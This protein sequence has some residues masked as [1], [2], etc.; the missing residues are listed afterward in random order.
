MT[1][2]EV[3]AGLESFGGATIVE[4][5]AGGPASDSYFVERGAER[6]VLRIDTEVAAALGLERSSEVKILEYVSRY[7]L[8]P[9]PEFV[10]PQRGILV[11]RYFEGR[12]WSNSD[13]HDSDRIQKLATLLRTLHKL[14][15]VGQCFDLQA[16]IENYA[17]IIGSAEGRKLA[18]DTQRRLCELQPGSATQCLCHNDLVC[19]NIIEGQGLVLIDWEYAAIGDPFFDLA[20][21]AEHHHLDANE[22]QQLLVAYCGRK[23]AAD[24]ERLIRHRALYANLKMLWLASVERLVPRSSTP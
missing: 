11:T 23:H 19:T 18:D 15:P 17:R 5:L 3:L 16:K 22:S 10:D 13:L 9:K 20:I 7:G 4:E 24:A 2:E 12:A 6:F 8:G 1:P 14:Q 21:V